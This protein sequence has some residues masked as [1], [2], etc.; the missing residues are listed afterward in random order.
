MSLTKELREIFNN[1]CS[2]YEDKRDAIR[3]FYNG[4][5][6]CGAGCIN[7]LIYY[8]QTLALYNKYPIE[9][10][11]LVK[12]IKEE[13]GEVDIF[14][15]DDVE[16]NINYIIWLIFE[17][18]SYSWIQELEIEAEDDDDEEEVI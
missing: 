11:E 13:L 14:K 2:Y 17:Y 5:F 9:A 1:K 10:I 6:S 4:E 7:E 18:Y 8:R 16:M 3:G 15:Y 12:A